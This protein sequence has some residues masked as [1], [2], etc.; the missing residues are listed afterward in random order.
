MIGAHESNTMMQKKL[1]FVFGTR[2]EA[3][4]LAP[5]ILR[6]EKD[7]RFQVA[8]CS[9]G[10]HREML[11]PLL[12]FFKICPKYDLAL[13]RPKPDLTELVAGAMTGVRDIL[14]QENPDFTI[15]QGDTST[16]MA[17]ALAAFHERKPVAHV[18]AGLRSGDLY[19]PWPEELNRRFVTL[20]ASQ[21]FAPT[22][23]SLENLQKE[24]VDKSRLH[25][26]GNTVID[27]LLDVSAR[28][29][30]DKGLAQ[31]FA[32][33]YK[34]LDSK[35]RLLLVTSHRR[36]SFSG[37]LESILQALG[38]ISELEDVQ[39]LF[40]VHFNPK[41]RKRVAQIL[42]AKGVWVKDGFDPANINLCDP[43][44]YLDFIYLMKRC[45]FILSDSGGVQEEAPALGKPVLVLREV[46]ERPEAIAAGTSILVGFDRA[47]IVKS[48]R[49]LLENQQR[50]EAMAHANNP[51]GDGHACER[52][53]DILAQV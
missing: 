3:I 46:T 32:E 20:M 29:D 13:M 17:A 28:L 19:S 49:A 48:A 18:E 51:F 30:Q 31:A 38:D 43:L 14:R 52:I 9:T 37:G 40:A 8:V 34:F 11:A 15:V 5:L 6:A 24:G 50:Y 25:M 16:C 10:Q 2:P 44:P 36:E 39:I 7:P 42:G 12:E 35:K 22:P 45:Y 47:G 21:H 23:A 33:K 41:V 53:L 27:A 4:K 1:L 26:T